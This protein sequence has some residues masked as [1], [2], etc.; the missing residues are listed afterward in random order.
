MADVAAPSAVAESASNLD[1]HEEKLHK[2]KPEKPDEEKYKLDLAQAEKDH[3]AVQEKLVCLS[4]RVNA[5][6][7]STI[8]MHD[9][10][11]YIDIYIELKILC[12]ECYQA[13]AR[14]RQTIE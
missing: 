14:Y 8:T 5:P 10:A 3:A 9:T 6:F 13:Q 1:A 7:T 2:T 12:L 11:V 4:I